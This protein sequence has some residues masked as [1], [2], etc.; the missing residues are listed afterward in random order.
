MEYQCFECGKE[1]HMEEY[2][3]HDGICIDCECN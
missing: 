2:I 3:N 1:M